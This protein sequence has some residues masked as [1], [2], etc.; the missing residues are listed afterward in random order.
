MT[1]IPVISPRRCNTVHCG[2]QLGENDFDIDVG[3]LPP[4]GSETAIKAL[5][6]STLLAT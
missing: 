2:P 1:R 4:T 6:R 3:E 5:F